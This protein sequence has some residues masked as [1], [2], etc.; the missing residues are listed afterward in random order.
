MRISKQLKSV[1]ICML[2]VTA[3]VPMAAMIVLAQDLT[4]PEIHDVTL[5]PKYPQA[6]DSHMFAA[7]IIDAESDIQ[8]VS[9]AYCPLG[10]VCNS[11]DMFDLDMDDVYEA[12]IGP[13]PTGAVYDYFISARN[14][15]NKMNETDMTWVKVAADITFSSTLSASTIVQGKSVR[16]NGTAL[17][18]DNA[19]TPVETSDVRLTIEGTS[20]DVSDTTDSQGRFNISFMAPD[21]VGD[22]EVNVSVTNRSLSNYSL[23]PLNTTLPGD[24]D[25]DGLTDDEEAILGTDPQ[26][27]DT[28]GDGLDDYEEVNA[29][30][31]GYITNATNSDTDGDGLSDWEEVKEGEDTFLTDPTNEDT[32]GDGAIDSEDW[33]PID[34]SVQDE[35]K[36]EDLTWMYLLIAIIVIVVIVLAVLLMRRRSNA[37]TLELEEEDTT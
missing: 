33:N 15:E 26:N 10:E 12:T 9:L 34:S 32:D 20:V 35:P 25:G 3:I 31:D 14:I 22:F 37:G 23:A 30:D 27:P 21:S 19:T 36:D 17:Y 2:I 1:A 29:G 7:R 13:F 6:A 5:T 24:A 4:P 16:A 18:D 8:V 11:I 28:D